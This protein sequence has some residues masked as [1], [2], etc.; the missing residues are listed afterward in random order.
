MVKP[1]D[2]S[3]VRLEAYL[4]EIVD[5]LAENEG[6]PSVL[7]ARVQ[8]ILD[9]HSGSSKMLDLIDRLG[10]AELLQRYLGKPLPDLDRENCTAS[11]ARSIKMRDISFISLLVRHGIRLIHLSKELME[12]A[13]DAQDADFMAFLRAAL[14]DRYHILKFATPRCI[15]DEC[16][17]PL[18]P[19]IAEELLRASP[20]DMVRYMKFR[21]NPYITL[22]TTAAL[23]CLDLPEGLIEKNRFHPELHHLLDCVNSP[24]K[25]FRIRGHEPSLQRVLARPTHAEFFGFRETE[26]PGGHRQIIAA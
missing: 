12:A 5:N 19:F 11:F 16:T 4:E 21:G 18:A 22:K 24:A 6:L 2:I 20:G 17:R 8:A 23:L 15:I 3:P 7:Q 25:K 9:L 1:A 13:L 14:E 26:A 10:S